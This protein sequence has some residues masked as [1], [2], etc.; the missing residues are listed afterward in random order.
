MSSNSLAI[1][2]TQNQDIL[3]MKTGLI[4]LLGIDLWE[5]A[6]YLQYKNDRPGYVEKIL[7]IMNWNG[8][9]ETLKNKQKEAK[10]IFESKYWSI[11]ANLL[12]SVLLLYSKSIILNRVP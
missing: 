5:H 12:K 11:S 8:A 2:T 10:T 9:E 7:T 4:P 6:Y 1:A 3:Q